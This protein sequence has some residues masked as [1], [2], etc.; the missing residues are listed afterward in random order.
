MDVG[1]FVPV[2]FCYEE[3]TASRFC[4]QGWLRTNAN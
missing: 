2:G 4:D 1:C 3:E